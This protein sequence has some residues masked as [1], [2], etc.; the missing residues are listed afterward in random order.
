MKTFIILLSL[1][2]GSAAQAE[3]NTVK[4]AAEQ[5]CV[6]NVKITDV[7]KDGAPVCG[8]LFAEKAK[9]KF[10]KDYLGAIK[11]TCIKADNTT[12]KLSFTG[13][14][15]GIY[16]VSILHDRNNNKELDRNWIGIPKEPVAISNNA[17]GTMGP[18]DFEDAKITV[19][20][21]CKAIEVKMMTF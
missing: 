19:S 8:F 10:P 12:L 18:P 17:K 21:E 13:V 3:E 16:A 14:A 7:V 9:D 1:L 5:N 11:K 15:H 2:A 6:L 20:K 4:V